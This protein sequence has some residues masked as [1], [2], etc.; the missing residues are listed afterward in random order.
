M[1]DDWR[2]T[3][4]PAI[5]SEPVF[6][7]SGIM[8]LASF[9]VT[10]WMGRRVQAVLSTVTATVVESSGLLLSAMPGLLRIFDSPAERAAVGWHHGDRETVP[11]DGAR[12]AIAVFGE[13]YG[14]DLHLPPEQFDALLPMLAGAQSARLRIEVERTLDQ[15][16]LDDQKLFWNDRLSPRIVFDEFEISV[17]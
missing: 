1:S 11:L 4:G 14:I 6:D 7:L 10:G 2:V 9:S 15:G 17:P 13:R 8:T 12:G 16:L 5:G 3:E